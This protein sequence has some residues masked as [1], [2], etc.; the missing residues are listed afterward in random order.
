[1]KFST[2]KTELLQALQKVS[3]ASPT[4]STLPILSCVLVD[5]TENKTT[6]RAT[7]LE[8]TIQVAV[9]VSLEEP[10]SV[11]LPLKTL[12]DITNELPETRL[13][14]TAD[15]KNKLEI[16][17]ESGIYDLMGKPAFEFPEMPENTKT[18]SVK[19]DSN[20]LKQIIEST[21]FAVSKDELK[22]AL[23]GVL[24]RFSSS[25][26]TAVSTDGHRLVKH[27]QKNIDEPN[28]VGDIIIPRK[29]LSFISTQLRS[30]ALTLEIGDTHLT[31]AIHN[32][33]ILTRLIDEKFP[34]YEN[35]IPKD[36]EN[37]LTIDKNMFLGA[38]KRVSIFSNKS[39]HQIA[40]NLS[41]ESSKITTEDPEQSSRA[42]EVIVGEYVGENLEIGYNSEYL[43]DVVQHVKGNKIVVR[44]NTPI[45]AALFSPETNEETSESLMLLMPIR[46]ND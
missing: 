40:L 1:M 27:T 37:V 14:L 24:F 41:D 22:P 29:F 16:Q 39:T 11:A 13:T 5:A 30:D 34:D 43:K 17:T 25:A 18:G 10:G 15:D 8:L 38:I 12:M 35:V 23:S 6:L 45:S 46:L 7:D 26:L 28:Y 31:A 44:L 3:K 36:N 4:R 42:Q 20:T 9:S 19:S 2:S 33:M 21:L 32:D